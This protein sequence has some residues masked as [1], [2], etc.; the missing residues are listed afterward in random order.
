[1]TADYFK[2][3]ETA[4]P[5][6]IVRIIASGD[7]N[8][9]GLID[10]VFADQSKWATGVRIPLRLAMYDGQGGFAVRS[11]LSNTD[12]PSFIDPRVIVSDF[13]GDAINDLVIYDGGWYDGMSHGA[14]P[15][16]LIG[17][18]SGV[19]TVSAALKDALRP[20]VTAKPANY[21]GGYQV[22]LT[23][24]VKDIA[25]ADIDDDGDIDLWIEST[26]G[27][28]LTSHFVINDGAGNFSV[29]ID[30]RIK[31]SLLFGPKYNNHTGPD[32]YRYGIGDFEDVNSDGKPDL[33]LGQIRDNHP[34]HIDQ[35]S[36]LL[37]NNGRGYYPESLSIKLPL[38][39]FYHGYTSVQDAA[40]WDVNQD[41][42]KDL[43]LVHTR[44]DG[45][46]G[47]D[48]E[49]PWVGTYIQVLISQS[50]TDFVDKTDFYL[51]DQALWS[52]LNNKSGQHARSITPSDINHDGRLDFLLSYSIGLKPS[53][54][55]PLG[56]WATADGSFR[57]IDP[58]FLTRGD[59]TFGEGLIA[60]DFQ[61]DNLMDFVHLDVQKGPN[62]HY[63]GVLSD[64]YDT[65]ILQT[66]TS[67]FGIAKLTDMAASG[68]QVFRLY[69]TVLGRNPEADPIGCGFWI[70]K[71]E[72]GILT[73]EQMVANFLN[74]TEFISRFGSS[75]S[76]ND[77]FVNLMY[78]NLLGRDGYPDNGFKFWLNVLN[79]NLASR[80]QVVVGFMNS[81]ENVANAAPLIGDAATYQEWLG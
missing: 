60:I 33:I 4:V 59:P 57:S 35:S 53:D 47:S 28:N 1:M 52:S 27:A 65:L 75:S 46:T 40:S 14:E 71:L 3:T 29:D 44:N 43:I 5:A 26:G 7:I 72:K 12:V 32:Y 68:G 54:E 69:L 20:L 41:G 13:T 50:G 79:A 10:L 58:I 6:P 19:F 61:K 39:N 64:D 80:E 34:T 81:P 45:V 63:D 17:S 55:R 21:G 15:V 2:I 11:I 42:Y 76:S 38:P 36:Y 66:G 56:F 37:L 78:Q 31:N 77:S 23:V 73:A 49:T 16:L 22:D 30:N 48:A 25:S 18:P 24:G 67:E 70:D 8:N 62:Q 9:D 51:G 74:S